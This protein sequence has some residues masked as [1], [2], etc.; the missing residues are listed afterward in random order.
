MSQPQV[1]DEA[2]NVPPARR[3]RLRGVWLYL[4]ILATVYVVASLVLG[5]VSYTAMRS[6]TRTI[7]SNAH[8]IEQLQTDTNDDLCNQQEYEDATCEGGD[9]N[10]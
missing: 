8:Q 10:G 7:Q 9:G 3:T 5:V 2:A 4:A 6:D 1:I